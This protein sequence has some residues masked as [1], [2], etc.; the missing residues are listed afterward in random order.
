MR[1]HVRRY[2]GK[3]VEKAVA[4]VKKLAEAIKGMI[5]VLLFLPQ[6]SFV[7][8]HIYA[9]TYAY[10]Y[11]SHMYT[12]LYMCVCVCVCLFTEICRYL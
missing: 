4:N 3:G 2:L 11:Y 7:C 5:C 1:M 9:H 12:Y 10:I 6:I 8:V